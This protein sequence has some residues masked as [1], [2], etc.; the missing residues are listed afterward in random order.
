MGYFF[1]L[2]DISQKENTDRIC[3][4]SADDGRFGRKTGVSDD[5]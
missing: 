1:A 2:Q 5:F 3:G 4:L